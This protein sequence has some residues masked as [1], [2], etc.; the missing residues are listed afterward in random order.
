MPQ[1]LSGNLCVIRKVF[2]VL[3]R[4]K[5]KTKKKFRDR[6]SASTDTWLWFAGALNPLPPPHPFQR[7]TWAVLRSSTLRLRSLPLSCMFSCR[8][9][10]QRVVLERKRASVQLSGSDYNLFFPLSLNKTPPISV[11]PRTWVVPSP[12]ACV[13][14]VSKSVCFTRVTTVEEPGAL[15][16]FA[17][18]RRAGACWLLK[19]LCLL[20]AWRGWRHSWAL[21]HGAQGFT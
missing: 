18:L 19:G 7:R 2:P 16:C 21:E 4:Q 17:E 5:N 9:V 11:C 15:S 1:D 14:C 8:C 10:S 3:K 12:R 13:L 20:H 6:L